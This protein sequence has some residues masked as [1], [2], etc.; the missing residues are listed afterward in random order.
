M[1]LSP[2]EIMRRLPP[3][4]ASG[5]AIVGGADGIIR[6]IFC[7]AIDNDVNF[8]TSIAMPVNNIA[9]LRDMLNQVLVQAQVPTNA[10]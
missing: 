3:R 8:H 2:G 4:F 1:P 7:D 6:I 10:N 5:Q 9:A